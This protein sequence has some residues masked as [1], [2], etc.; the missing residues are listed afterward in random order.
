M[1][2][3]EQSKILH[4]NITKPCKKAKCTGTKFNLSSRIEKLAKVLVYV[5][6][7]DRNEH[8]QSN[9]FC[10]LITPSKNE[11]RRISKKSST[12]EKPHGSNSNEL[13]AS[14]K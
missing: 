9:S 14:M 6:I 2:P 13:I 11:L 10:R 7:K 5:T 8:F 1:T 3:K 12:N 4:G